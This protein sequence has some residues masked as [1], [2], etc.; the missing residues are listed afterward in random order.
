MTNQERSNLTAGTKVSA[1]IEGSPATKKF[2]QFRTDGIQGD[3]IGGYYEDVPAV[4]DKWVDAEIV[5]APDSKGNIRLFVRWTNSQGYFA[6][7]LL[8]KF[9]N[10]D[11]IIKED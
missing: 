1:R 7:R 5:K 10:K 2:H 4:P 9:K 8:Y 11:I 6:K 3:D